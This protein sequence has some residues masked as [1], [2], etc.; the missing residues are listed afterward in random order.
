MKFKWL[1]YELFIQE[2]AENWGEPRAT[3]IPVSLC[4]IEYLD[5]IFW[6]ITQFYK[7]L[8]GMALKS[9]L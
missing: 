1:Y 9:P 4:K 3:K 2:H 8:Y 5:N 6:Q 7:V